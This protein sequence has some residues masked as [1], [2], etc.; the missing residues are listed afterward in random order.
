MQGEPGSMQERKYDDVVDEVVKYL[1]HKV[2]ELVNRGHK[3]ENIVIDP[4][5]VL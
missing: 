4:E 2:Q 5:S 3:K 1:D